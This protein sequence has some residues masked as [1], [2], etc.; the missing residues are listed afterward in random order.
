[1][2][3]PDPLNQVQ[4]CSRLTTWRMGSAHLYT[5]L[6]NLQP[7]RLQ[8]VSPLQDPPPRP[9]SRGTCRAVSP[10]TRPDLGHSV[11]PAIQEQPAFPTPGCLGELLEPGLVFCVTAVWGRR[12]RALSDIW[13]ISRPSLCHLSLRFLPCIPFPSLKEKTITADTDSPWSSQLGWEPLSSTSRS[14]FS[15]WRG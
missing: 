5:V 8:F 12:G 7:V 14:S 15:S 11:P 13:D 6:C 4:G 2:S 1:M 9:S 3:V 10:K